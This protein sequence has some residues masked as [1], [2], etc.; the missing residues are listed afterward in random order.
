MGKSP[1]T[2]TTRNEPPSW[3][4]PYFRDS[5]SRAQSISQRPF[6]PYGGNAVAGFT[7]DQLVGMQMTRDNAFANTDLFNQGRQSLMQT[8]AGQDNPYAG[9][10]PF[11]QQMIDAS[12]GDV[13]RN[14][15]NAIQP[16]LMG[17]FAAGGAFGGSAYRQ[18]LAGAQRE[19]A[20]ELGQVS[21][22]LRFNDY[23]MQAQLAESGAN[24]RLGAAN[25]LGAFANASGNPGQSL[26]GIGGLQQGL[27]QQGLNF[28]LSEFMRQQG[29]DANQLG[30]LNQSLGSI[31]GAFQNQTG[32]NP[33][34]QSPLQ[35]LLGLG[36][37]LGGSIAQGAWI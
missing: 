1:R 6:Q 18:A 11:L 4:I 36:L 25:S 27:T 29:W 22:G 32:P 2:T 26:L 20:D 8:V 34:Y 23:N 15:T 21:S 16:G 30:I 19:L 31:T 28:D 7:P 10:N 12:A 5:L 14:F 9:S 24:R 37:T 13:T 35:S 3:A 33:N 17:Q